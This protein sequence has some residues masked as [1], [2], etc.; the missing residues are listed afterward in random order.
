MANSIAMNNNIVVVLVLLM[1]VEATILHVAYGNNDG[2]KKPVLFIFGDSTADVGTNNFL[3]TKAKANMPYNGI[4]FA[5]S[6]PTGR[7]SNGF[8]TIDYIGNNYMHID[9]HYI[10]E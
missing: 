1:C 8:N 7:F 4:D 6:K 10:S 2:R 3:P 9:N 5:Q